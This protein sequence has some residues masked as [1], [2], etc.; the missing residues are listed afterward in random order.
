MDKK[1]NI[2]DEEAKALLAFSDLRRSTIKNI[3]SGGHERYIGWIFAFLIGCGVWV[4]KVDELHSYFYYFCAWMMALGGQQM[5]NE[6]RFN[7]LIDFLEKD[8]VIRK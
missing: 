2:S 7:A 3:R 8:G 5:W 1:T 6:R 4:L